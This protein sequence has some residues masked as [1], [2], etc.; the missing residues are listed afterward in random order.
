[1]TTAGASERVKDELEKKLR[2]DVEAAR[3][4]SHSKNALAVLLDTFKPADENVAD[5]P[6]AKYRKNPIKLPGV[7]WHPHVA[8]KEKEASME[9]DMAV[10]KEKKVVAA[11][12]TGVSAT[13]RSKEPRDGNT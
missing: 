13:E 9:S 1:M 5:D 10:S 2:K 12:V 7:M 4:A 11:P 3:Y 8:Q 6:N